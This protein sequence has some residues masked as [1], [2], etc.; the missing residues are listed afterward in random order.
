VANGYATNH[1]KDVPPLIGGDAFHLVAV[2]GVW[3]L[4]DIAPVHTSVEELQ[5]IATP[6]DGGC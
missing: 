6:Y 5:R 3:R 4:A 1:R 2:D